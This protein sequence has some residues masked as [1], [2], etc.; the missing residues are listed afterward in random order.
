MPRHDLCDLLRIDE[1]AADLRGLVDA[2]C[3]ARDPRSRPTAGARIV[4]QHNQIGVGEA[5]QRA[6]RVRHRRDDFAGFAH[7][8]GLARLGVEDLDHLV[9]VQVHAL[10]RPAFVRR[11]Q[12]VG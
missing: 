3:D 7:R 9:W 1:H 11:I 5:K 8:D 10:R 2:A 12:P 4:A 6:V